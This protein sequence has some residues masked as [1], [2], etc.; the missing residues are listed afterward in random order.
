MHEAKVFVNNYDA[1]VRKSKAPF[2]HS[3]PLYLIVQ[4]LESL[5]SLTVRTMPFRVRETNHSA[6]CRASLKSSM[7]N[8]AID[9]TAEP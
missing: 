1:I 9:G 6:R 2:S 5:V 7:L 3:L 4:F 8:R